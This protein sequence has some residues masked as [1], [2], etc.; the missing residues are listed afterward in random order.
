M[1][2]LQVLHKA[3]GLE[4]VAVREHKFLH[5]CGRLDRLAQ[6]I[7][8]QCPVYQAHGHGLAFAVAKRQT[9]AARELRRLGLAAGKLIN[10]LTLRD[11]DV[12][13]RD[14]KAKLLWNDL[15]RHLAQANLTH[16]GV[17]VG[18]TALGRI[19]H[20]QQ[21]AFIT[22]RQVLQ[23]GRA[24]GRKAQGVT[25]EVYGGGVTRRNGPRFLW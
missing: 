6:L 8:A 11:F 23:A 21:E 9:I 4:T 2:Q 15:Q 13:H 3:G 5:L 12:T 24:H 14:G 19:S 20:R 18:V 16:K 10:H 17:A 7:G 22:T 1:R 25:G